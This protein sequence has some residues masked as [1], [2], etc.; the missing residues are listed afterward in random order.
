MDNFRIVSWNVQGLGGAQAKK[1]KARLRQ[2]SILMGPCLVV[3][4]SIFGVLQL[5]N[6][7]IK[8]VF[9]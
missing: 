7:T 3:H 5:A 6:P 1:F 8:L 2:G 9:V 4:G